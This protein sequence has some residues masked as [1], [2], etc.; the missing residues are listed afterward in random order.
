MP[1][2]VI[3]Q[4][5]RSSW[6]QQALQADL[7]PFMGYFAPQISPIRWSHRETRKKWKKN[8]NKSN[9][10]KNNPHSS[11]ATSC[12][13]MV[14]QTLPTI[15]HH[16]PS[17]KGTDWAPQG[18]SRW[19]QGYCIPNGPSALHTCS[20]HQLSPSSQFLKLGGTSL[21]LLRGC[22]FTTWLFQGW[23]EEKNGVGTVTKTYTESPFETDG[24]WSSTGLTGRRKQQSKRGIFGK[25]SLSSQVSGEL[26]IAH[27]NSWKARNKTHLPCQENTVH[28]TLLIWLRTC[29]DRSTDVHGQK[30]FCSLATF[31]WAGWV[32]FTCFFVAHTAGR[33]SL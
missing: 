18:T 4:D 32:Y 1:M 17:P 16:G 31:S 20:F 13:S 5:P 33:G 14:I 9:N 30:H 26:H 28:K 3:Q 15:E 25:S 24:D 8:Q 29:P 7:C 12:S 22:S 6:E 27:S 10:N 19:L 11:F 23:L 2:V 21:S